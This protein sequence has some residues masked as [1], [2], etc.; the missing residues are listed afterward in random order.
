MLTLETSVTSQTVHGFPDEVILD[1]MIIQ[2]VSVGFT[3]TVHGLS[4]EV[5]LDFT[6]LSQ[7]PH[8]CNYRWLQFHLRSVLLDY[9]IIFKTILD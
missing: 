7:Y 4:D 3:I 1:L 5:I 9:I 2:H 8:G 6:R